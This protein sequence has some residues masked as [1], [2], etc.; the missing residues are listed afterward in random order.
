MAVSRIQNNQ[1][2]YTSSTSGRTCAF[3][4]NVT[5]NSL[6]VAF[7]S[8][9][10]TNITVSLTD[11][12]GQTWV[13]AGGYV[14]QGSLKMSL[15]YVAGSLAGADTLT[16]TPS[17]AADVSI[18]IIEYGGIQ[19]TSPLD[20]VTTNNAVGSSTPFVTYGG[21]KGDLVVGGMAQGTATLSFV[22]VDYPFALVGNLLTVSGSVGMESADAITSVG[23]LANVVRF[24]CPQ[25][26]DFTAISASFKTIAQ[27]GQ[28]VQAIPL[29]PKIPNLERDP[30]RHRHAHDLVEQI[31]NSLIRQGILSRT[32]QDDWV[33]NSR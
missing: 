22:T 14:T 8:T 30:E 7:V 19:T 17:A 3:P 20:V 23:T 5:V 15:W 2:Q 24:T 11:T 18:Q 25:G 16:V 33:I 28:L 21:A 32:T 9:F 1:A 12:L 4:S 29:I 6:L 26:V 27:E 10:G 13:Q 31:F